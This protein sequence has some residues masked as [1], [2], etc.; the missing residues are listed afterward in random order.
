[1]TLLGTLA[2]RARLPTADRAMANVWINDDI[3][4]LEP[5]R[6][7]WTTWTFVSFWLVNQIAS[8]FVTILRRQPIF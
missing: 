6:R 2:A 5:E 4:P 3:R 1:M 8:T 7:T